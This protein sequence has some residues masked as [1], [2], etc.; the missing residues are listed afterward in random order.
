MNLQLL[1]YSPLKEEEKSVSG[2]SKETV[3]YINENR[4]K[5][6][7][8][9]KG[10]AK[11]IS[12]KALQAADV[13]DIYSEILMYMYKSDDYNISKAVERSSN[14]T[15]VSLE[16]YV[17]TCIRFC[18]IRYLT[19]EYNIQKETVREFTEQDG[20]ELSIF[21]TLSDGEEKHYDDLMFDIEEQCET[22]EYLRYKF[23]PDLYMLWYVR[24]LTMLH[25][26][27]RMYKEILTILGVTKKDLENIERNAYQ[28]DTMRSF[29]KSV[30]SCGLEKSIQVIEKYVY[31]A[32]NIKN[33]VVSC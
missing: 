2:W 13:D 7:K 26:K 5:V 30:S 21:D 27:G 19:T 11:G 32:N 4:G 23:G 15:L 3:D 14:G 29:A 18:V 10:I 9:I 16:G 12:R 1:V 28:D 25:G 20:K 24:I 31:S 8:T 22:S 17:N 6:I 33:V